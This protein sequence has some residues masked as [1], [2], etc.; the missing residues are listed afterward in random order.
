M[1]DKKIKIVILEKYADTAPFVAKA[2]ESADQFK[3]A[4]GF[5]ATRVFH[6][7]ARK[8]QLY[9]AI[10]QPTDKKWEYAG[11]LLFDCRPPKASI[12]QMLALPQYRNFGIATTLLNQ[13][14]E[15]LTQFQYISI[16]AR[17]A[18][19][20]QANAFWE[21]M[22]FYVQRI[23]RGGAT[24]NRTILVRSHELRSPQ[25]FP[26]S[27]LSTANPLGLDVTDNE[28]P[29]Y[30][31]D[32]NVLFDLAPRRPRNDVTVDLFQTERLGGFKFAVSSE[33]REELK[34]T[35]K[36]G[37]TDQMQAYT[38]IFSTFPLL[39]G[40]TSSQLQNDLAKLIFPERS[41]SDSLTHNDNSDLIHLV[42]AI[43]HKLA[44]FI[45]NDSFILNA[46]VALKE[47]YEIEV[48][49]PIAFK[50]ASHFS[51]TEDSYETSSDPLYITPIKESQEHAV[52]HLL[53]KLKVPS[54]SLASDWGCGDTSNRV[55][56]RQGLWSESGLIGYFSSAPWGPNNSTLL[57][58]AIDESSPNAL[59]AA[60]VLLTSF[61][62]Q[63]P[64]NQTA[65]IRLEFPPHQSHVRE[66]AASLGFRGTSSPIALSKLL[67]GKIVTPENWESC[68]KDL[69]NIGNLRLPENVPSFRNID[70]KLELFTPDGNR[71]YLSF[72]SL[73]TLLTPALFC[74]P[75]RKSVI[76]PINKSFSDLLLGHSQQR[77]LLPSSRASLYQEKHYF[78][79]PRTLKFFQRGALI[80]F[81]ESQRKRG[82]GAIVAVARVKQAYLKPIEILNSGDLDPSVLSQSTLSSIG[83]S[84]EKTV[85]AF[86]NLFAFPKPVSLEILK[87]LGCGLP[88]DL[89]T[90]KPINDTQLQQIIS[91]GFS[92][93]S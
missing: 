56:V 2:S 55:F 46:S 73:E 54:S 26:T 66:I 9:I 57:K 42:T 10:H 60:R 61:L 12:L 89:I 4:L 91:A 82:L 63:I 25:L 52:H 31:L 18:E 17:V 90:T 40:E 84:E 3:D 22:D 65:K 80:L 44:G 53:T 11:H 20:L 59:N 47:R 7:F 8:D 72:E 50:Q 69:L 39:V 21:K 5:F 15:K 37:Q 85:T 70:Q 88:S 30:L 64:V 24:R 79:D 45:T 29:T 35:A 19:D 77:S 76:S 36:V 62:H 43:Q 49:S 6:E 41:L 33:L 78:S 75:G 81:Y 23:E 83:K 74:L 34:R 48:I 13:L 32:L 58:V 87:R 93:N 38:R 92:E 1:T 28:V 27:G 86:D 14:K 68:R 71:S 67:M 51:S 16:R